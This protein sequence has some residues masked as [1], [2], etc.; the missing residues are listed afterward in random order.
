MY[1]GIIKILSN[2]YAYEVKMH[3]RQ[4]IYETKQ[5]KGKYAFE[6]STIGFLF[7]FF[8]RMYSFKIIF[9]SSVYLFEYQGKKK[10][11]AVLVMYENKS[12]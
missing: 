6:L 2:G 12:Y 10:N 4:E 7:L 8:T 1:E 9:A 5:N 11:N 3:A